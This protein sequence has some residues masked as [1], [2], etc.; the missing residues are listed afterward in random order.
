MLPYLQRI[1]TFGVIFIQILR[2]AH[3]WAT[4]FLKFIMF[5]MIVSYSNHIVD[6]SVSFANKMAK[7]LMMDGFK[8]FALSLSTYS[9]SHFRETVWRLHTILR[10]PV[11][12]E[13]LRNRTPA[14]F[15]TLP[16]PEVEGWLRGG[17]GAR[18]ITATPTPSAQKPKFLAV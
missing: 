12:E 17:S 2:S 18:T 15:C 4:N 8:D 13:D 11:A 10:T 14:G 9:F 1:S 5:G 16:L 6:A 7:R 3:P